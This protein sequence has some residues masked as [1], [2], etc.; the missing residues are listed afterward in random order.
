MKNQPADPL[1]FC[2]HSSSPLYC[3]EYLLTHE[4]QP[5][6][7]IVNGWAALNLMFH[8]APKY[9]KKILNTRKEKK[10]K[11]KKKGFVLHLYQSKQ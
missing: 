10:R 2:Q 9:Q 5:E 6:E 4:P 1:K 7:I 11:E 3:L 8:D